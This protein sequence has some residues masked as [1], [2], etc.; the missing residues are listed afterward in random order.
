[1]DIAA[2]GTDLRENDAEAS[3]AEYAVDGDDDTSWTFNRAQRNMAQARGTLRF[4]GNA[5]SGGHRRVEVLHAGQWGTICDD[6]FDVE[7]AKVVCRQLGYNVSAEGSFGYSTSVPYAYNGEK[8]WLD[9]VGCAGGEEAI[10]LC[11]HHGWGQVRSCSQS[12]DVGVVCHGELLPPAPPVTVPPAWLVVALRVRGKMQPL[13]KVG[14]VRIRWAV[15]GN[16]IPSFELQLA[17]HSNAAGSVSK[18]T[19]SALDALPVLDPMVAAAATHGSGALSGPSGW[20]TVHSQAGNS[21]P[22]T[23][24]WAS[25]NVMFYEDGHGFVVQEIDLPASDSYAT[26]LRLWMPGHA[27]RAGVSELQVM[28]C[29]DSVASVAT[30][31]NGFEYRRDMTPTITA[32]S[33]S[34]GSTAGGTLVQIR[35]Q[36]LAPPESIRSSLPEGEWGVE[37]GMVRGAPGYER[38][39]CEIVSVSPQLIVCRTTEV[40]VLDGGTSNAVV[41]VGGM[42]TSTPG[43]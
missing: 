26:H 39:P 35:G 20:R 41:D 28:G 42:G 32:V 5:L 27:S 34:R 30:M 33:P 11:S 1:M 22:G 25:S 13:A 36:Q 4:A 29:D 31:P 9:N 10:Q 6:N 21:L 14:R 40:S 8:I 7:D 17:K 2:A 24:T 38:V 15:Y 18:R 3:H 23:A 19:L 16:E 37:V 12:E 43:L